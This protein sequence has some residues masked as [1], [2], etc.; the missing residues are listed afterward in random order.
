MTYRR[1]IFALTGGLVACMV[2]TAPAVAIA[3]GTEGDGEDDTTISTTKPSTET[4]TRKTPEQKALDKSAAATGDHRLKDNKLKVCK[5]R[6]KNITTIMT[7]H[8][9][10]ANKQMEVF[11]KITDRVEKF[12]QEKGKTV[13][14]Y[15]ELVAAVDTAMNK[16]Q[17]DIDALKDFHFSCDSTDPKSTATEFKTAIQTEIKDMKAYKTAVVNLIKAVKSAQGEEQ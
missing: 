2:A 10:R 4:E 12:Y 8:V 1:I 17:T 6:E 13:A 14:N 16:A 9:E 7:N 15:D 5:N 3:H 11:M